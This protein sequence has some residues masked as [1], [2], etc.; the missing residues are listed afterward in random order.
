MFHLILLL[1]TSTT[2]IRSSCD[3]SNVNINKNDKQEHC[4][5]Q[6]VGE[7]DSLCEDQV[8]IVEVL[9]SIVRNI[10]W[11]KMVDLC[12]TCLTSSIVLYTSPRVCYKQSPAAEQIFYFFF[13][14][15]S[16]ITLQPPFF[17]L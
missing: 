14:L 16:S 8:C 1:I 2:I 6:V 15:V 11:R 13:F 7:D 10:S 3:Q 9:P 17:F 12:L 4:S 5:R